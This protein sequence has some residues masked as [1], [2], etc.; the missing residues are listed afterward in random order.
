MTDSVAIHGITCAV[1]GFHFPQA[2]PATDICPFGI[3]G[4]NR[5]R[6]RFFKDGGLKRLLF[7]LFVNMLERLTRVEC[8]VEGIHNGLPCFR[9]IDHKILLYRFCAAQMHATAPEIFA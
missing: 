9:G 1:F 8:P 5:N 2:F 3:A 4:N 7:D 6:I